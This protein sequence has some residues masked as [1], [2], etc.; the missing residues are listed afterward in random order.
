MKSIKTVKV[1]S[2]SDRG[3]VSPEGG[4]AIA[5]D[6]GGTNLR[7]GIVDG[8]GVIILWDQKERPLKKQEIIDGIAAK[9]K[10]GFD[11]A[12]SRGMKPIGIGISTGGRV[13]FKRGIIVDAT[14]NLPDWRDVHIRDAVQEIVDLPVTVDNDGNCSAAAERVFGKAKTENNFISIALGTGIGGGIYVDGKLLRGEN[15]YAGEIGHV[16]V[17]AD[18][19]KCSCGAYGCVEMYSSGVGLVRWAQEEFPSLKDTAGNRKLT[20]K[21]IGESAQHGNAAAIELL[22]KAGTMLGAAVAGWLNTFNPSMIVLSGSLTELG[23]YYFRPFKDAVFQRAMVQTTEKLKIAFS[24]F[25][26]QAGII[27]A[28]S[29]VFQDQQEHGGGI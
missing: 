8:K 11:L 15:N 12:Q 23:E 25:H 9:A 13:D 24:D 10:E 21:S 20:A 27:G 6:L 4:A 22:K 26:N 1:K 7:L 16:T 5:I 14:G 18:G 28:A 3:G 29:L 19:P 17:N 2:A